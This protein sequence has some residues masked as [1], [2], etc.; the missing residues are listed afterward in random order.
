MDQHT[1]NLSLDAQVQRRGAE[2]PWS[3][4]RACTQYDIPQPT[5]LDKDEVSA[6]VIVCI[7]RL[8]ILKKL[9]PELRC[10]HLRCRLDNAMDRE[11][12]EAINVIKQIL[13]TEVI[14]RR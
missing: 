10:Q 9:A 12:A 6:R 1:E 7:K 2:D 11:D 3:L 4:F 14:R 13:C 5:T 8:E